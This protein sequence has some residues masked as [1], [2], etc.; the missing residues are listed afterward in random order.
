TIYQS[1]LPKNF[2]QALESDGNNG[3]WIGTSGGGHDCDML[4][5][6][7]YLQPSRHHLPVQRYLT[8]LEF[9][10][11]AELG[12]EMGFKNIA[13]GPMVRSSYHADQQAAGTKPV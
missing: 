7:Q 11:L 2:I 9:E 1:D 8:P 3:L 4:T 10:K 6:G 13:S 12:Y 5:L